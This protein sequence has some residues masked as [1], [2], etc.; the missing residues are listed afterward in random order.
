MVVVLENHAA[1]SIIGSD[2][3]PYL[4][5]LAASG[6]S[7]TESYAITHPSQPNYL[8][9]FSGS[10]QGVTGDSCP[11]TFS[12]PNLAAALA[13][14]GFSFAGYSD[15]LPSAGYTGCSDGAYARKHNPWVDFT[16]VSASANQPFTNF[17]QDY[18]RLPTVGFVIPNL[19]HDMHDGTIAQ[20]DT[21]LRTNLGGYAAW[22]RAHD[23]LLVVTFDED[24]FGTQ[25]R[26]ATIVAGA[27]LRAGRYAERIDHYRLLRTITA[28]YGVAPPGAAA[29]TPPITSI[30]QV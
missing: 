30:W 27:H 15:G 23:S 20:A 5:Q 9:L 8:A 4:N 25:N 24:D 16:N 3:A 21:W 1:D 2:Q 22:A 13:A 10:T 7:F 11:L 14:A 19:D 26:I 18:A 29:D 17:P 12:G 28:L 6:V